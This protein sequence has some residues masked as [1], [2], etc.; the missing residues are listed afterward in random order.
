MKGLLIL[1]RFGYQEN[2]AKYK[3]I[4]SQRYSTTEIIYTKYEDDL[5][6]AV[7]NWPF[8]GNILLHLMRWIKSFNYA[9]YA[10]RQ[11]NVDEII[12]LNP[13]VGIIIGLLSFKNKKYKLVVCGFL[14]EYKNNQ[15]Y[16]RLRQ[17]ITKIALNKISK[18]IVYGS[19]EVVHYEEIFKLK[20]KF[21][22]VPYG[23]D[24][25][26]QSNYFAQEL[27]DHYIFSGGGSNRD[28]ATLIKAYNLL[29]MQD[30]PLVIA[31]QPWRLNGLDLKKCK[32]LSNVVNE[33]F[34]DVMKKSDLLVLSLKK[35]KIS[36]GHMVMLQA[37]S[38]GVPVLVNDISAIRDYADETMVEFYPSGNDNVLA[39]TI[40]DYLNSDASLKKAQKAKAIYEKEYTS[41]ALVERIINIL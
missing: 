14:F 41:F 5:I 2:N 24:Y 6:R 7:R 22:F 40:Q 12:S 18:V 8:G 38:L 20:D 21:C 3:K 11:K 9:K 36:A 16:Y 39:N 35:T 28:F 25:M 30:S 34:G 37:M 1:D 32:I 33:T 29:E 13:I 31:T 19:T 17:F 4:I 27:P 10:L 26:N 23:I 15:L